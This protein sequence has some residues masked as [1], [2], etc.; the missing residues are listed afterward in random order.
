MSPRC[1][2][3][4]GWRADRGWRRRGRLLRRRLG[5]FP[6]PRRRRRR[7]K[8]RDA[9]ATLPMHNE[10]SESGGP[11]GEVAPSDRE[12]RD[13]AEGWPAEAGNEQL[14]R[15]AASLRAGRPRLS[16]EAIGRVA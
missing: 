4:G 16:Q 13:V 5:S 10:A 2:S 11:A 12:L 8:G 6:L 14:A 3:K 7:R 15:F 1:E 9:M